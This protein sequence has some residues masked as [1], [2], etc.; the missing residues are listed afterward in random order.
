MKQR[1]GFLKDKKMINIYQSSLRKREDPD[2]Q[3]KK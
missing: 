2:E 3:N 1:A